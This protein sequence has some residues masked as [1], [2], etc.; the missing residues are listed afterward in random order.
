MTKLPAVLLADFTTQLA[1][2]MAIGATIATLSSNIDDDGVTIPDGVIYLTIDGSNSGKEHIQAVKTGAN[3]ASIMSVS[4]QGVLTSGVLRKHRIGASVAMTD[5]ATIKYLTDLLK[6]T[7]NLDSADPLEYDGTA[8]IS[9]ANQL[10]TKAYV[11]GV[12]IA[13]GADASTTVKGIARISVAPASPTIPITVGDNDPRVPTQAENDALGG[14]NT[15][16][17]VGT[18]NKMVTQT[19]LQHGAEL[20]AADAGSNDT[21]VITLSPVPT[22]Y[23]TGMVVR[24]KANTIN[25]GAATLNVNSL[26]AKT[27]KKGVST[28]LS[29]GDILAGQFCTVIYDG[30]DFILQSPV[31]TNASLTAPASGTLALTSSGTSTV[32]CNF[33]ARRVDVYAVVSGGNNRGYSIGS[34]T[35]SGNN[36]VFLGYNSNGGVTS[37]GLSATTLFIYDGTNPTSSTAIINNITATTFDIVF[38][39]GTA[40]VDLVW[41][42]SV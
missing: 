6:G 23:T 10:T 7:T 30:T 42:A 36:C 38:T 34:Y 40:N 27:I 26:G 19:G 8:S 13:G 3:L 12:A 21:Y 31:A 15:D 29:N 9:T 14:N 24:F 35:A 17:A 33:L 18:G 11:D 37:A 1:S 28:T 32:T 2:E 20:Y 39:K 16:V 22:S 5:F 41:T 25:T 4:R